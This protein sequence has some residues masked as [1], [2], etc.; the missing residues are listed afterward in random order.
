MASS[1]VNLRS[2]TTLAVVAAVVPLAFVSGGYSDLA[3]G[4]IAVI[5]WLAV[6][7]RVLGGGAAM[8][9]IRSEFGWAAAALLALLV[10]TAFSLGWSGSDEAGFA[11]AVRLAGYLGAFVLAG[12]VVGRG[13][14]QAALAGVAV[15]GVIVGVVAVGSRLVGVGAGDA[16]LVGS[17]LSASG[18]LSYPIGYWNALGSLMAIVVPVLVW[19][20]AEA[21]ARGL[22]SLAVAAIVPVLLATYMTSSRGRCSPP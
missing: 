20:A 8:D 2:L 4:S 16:E 15:A 12:L 11:D 5:V 7:A 18:R 1:R 21:R 17:L 9:G 3:V 13:R 22:R 10:L 6:A 19:A 14:G